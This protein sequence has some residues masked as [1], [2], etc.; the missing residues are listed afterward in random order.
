MRDCFKTVDNLQNHDMK[1]HLNKGTHVYKC[2][3]CDQQHS[4]KNKFKSPYKKDHINCPLCK[5]IFQTISSL[6]VHITAVHD[7]ITVNHQ[8]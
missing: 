7:K 6:N 8:L 1:F 3:T 5:K 4:E 2:D